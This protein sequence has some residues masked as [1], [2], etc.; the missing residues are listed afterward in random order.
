MS[1]NEF[2]ADSFEFG[3]NNTFEFSHGALPVTAPAEPPDL[4][5]KEEAV[6][7]CGRLKAILHDKEVAYYNETGKAQRQSF[8]LSKLYTEANTEKDALAQKV[9]DLESSNEYKQKTL[10]SFHETLVNKSQ[11]VDVLRKEI[12]EY[13]KLSGSST[14]ELEKVKTDVRYLTEELGKLK[15]DKEESGKLKAKLATANS[16]SAEKS[17]SIEALQ[18]QVADNKGS[19]QLRTQVQKLKD[20]LE[21]KERTSET[22]RKTIETFRV[23][24]NTLKKKSTALRDAK[25]EIADKENTITTLHKQIGANTGSGAS[26][27][28]FQDLFNK[29]K[30]SDSAV[31]TTKQQL[32]VVRNDFEQHKE[33]LKWSNKA[34][35][36]KSTVI[37]ALEKDIRTIQANEQALIAQIQEVK[38]DKVNSINTV[39]TEKTNIIAALH[40]DIECI[41]A[42]EKVLLDRGQ[43]LLNELVKEKSGR[44][45]TEK[46][47]SKKIREVEENLAAAHL[48]ITNLTQAN[49]ARTLGEELRSDSNIEP[50]VVD[51]KPT[52]VEEIDGLFAD[53][54]RKNS[55]QA[56]EQV[57]QLAEDLKSEKSA[58]EQ[59]INSWEK[60]TKE[61]EDKLA[62]S[63]AAILEHNKT[64]EALKEQLK[65]EA[66]EASQRY[67]ELIEQANSQLKLSQR[68]TNEVS[69]KLVR[70][71]DELE[72]EKL[73]HGQAEESLTA[74]KRE[75]E[76]SQRKTKQDQE[77]LAAAQADISEYSKKISALEEQINAEATEANE[78]FNKFAKEI[79]SE[80]LGRE[81]AES[82]WDEVKSRL[83]VSQKKTK[84][85]EDKLAAANT[86][87]SEHSKTIEALENQIAEEE[88]EDERYKTRYETLQAECRDV[89][90]QLY[91]LESRT[92]RDIKQT[93]QRSDE[94]DDMSRQLLDKKKELVNLQLAHEKLKAQE[95]TRQQ[96]EAD[97]QEARIKIAAFEDQTAKLKL[98]LG[99]RPFDFRHDAYAIPNTMA[100]TFPTTR[101]LDDELRLTGASSRSSVFSD[102]GSETGD[103]HPLSTETGA[104]DDTVRVGQSAPYQPSFKP[105]MKYVDRNIY[106]PFTFSAHNPLLCWAH[107]ELGLLVLFLVWLRSLYSL[108]S[109]FIRHH[110]DITL[111][112]DVNLK[113]LSDTNIPGGP[114][115]AS[116]TDPNHAAADASASDPLVEKVQNASEQALKE[117]SQLLPPLEETEEHRATI[118]DP[119]AGLHFDQTATMHAQ[120]ASYTALLPAANRPWY[121][122]FTSPT[123][124]EIPSVTKTFTGLA[125]HLFVYALIGFGVS[126]YFERQLWLDAND[127]S[128]Q[129]L[130]HLIKNPHAYQSLTHRI[131]F[132]FPEDWKH[133]LDVFI[134]NYFVEKFN[135]HGSY[136]MPG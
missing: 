46:L 6:A 17:K 83:E 1:E 74:V 25:K 53:M 27:D 40:R 88:K 120:T 111:G 125:F 16:L 81:Q 135:L 33:K 112:N 11:E 64:I 54:E 131:C 72:R 9:R 134:F 56:T 116:E 86:T 124:D 59:T 29:L 38:V 47:W 45:E 127:H 126:C 132:A 76:A 60:K 58:H 107:T 13:Q 20:E 80:R 115:A 104:G 118:G 39:V 93:L 15:K 85:L 24:N 21:Q 3:S 113:S 32:E 89:K 35:L 50:M 71:S 77:K 34:V 37:Q 78:L 117:A 49:E 66:I 97:L 61:V 114:Q 42:N 31:A 106:T 26:S 79:D 2:T 136:V 123:P 99:R 52:E 62:T 82:G 4:A 102:D 84:E 94:Y 18:K 70:L 128:R 130:L 109:H 105:I 90:D 48:T 19:E 110:L 28:Q 98:D 55:E 96:I 43:G 12:K 68:K 41:R 51:D 95:E 129:F 22:L 92:Q 57:K 108:C 91:R 7:E 87:L 14:E 73:G 119:I 103:H 36:E 5:T 30:R 133:T 100:G 63:N 10:E 69:E 8:Q 122:K 67:Q 121:A 23:E 44:E 75:L 101:T 65:V